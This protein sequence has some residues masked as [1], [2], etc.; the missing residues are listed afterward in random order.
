MRAMLQQP[1]HP[2]VPAGGN[3]AHHSLCRL[4]PLQVLEILARNGTRFITLRSADGTIAVRCKLQPSSFATLLKKPAL[5]PDA[6]RCPSTQQAVSKVVQQAAPQHSILCP[7]RSHASRRSKLPWLSPDLMT[8]LA[9]LPL[10]KSRATPLH[11]CRCAGYDKVDLVAAERLGVAV[12]RVPSYSPASVAEHAVGM[13]MCLNRWGLPAMTLSCCFR[14]VLCCAALPQLCTPQALT[15]FNHGSP[16][17][18]LSFPSGLTHPA[19][20]S[21]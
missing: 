13:M 20:A 7:C 2:T 3:P 11:C 5:V 17:Q 1:C 6:P 12:T 19:G 9:H 4:A 10:F 8:R 15:W 16:A 21:I 18:A 14:R